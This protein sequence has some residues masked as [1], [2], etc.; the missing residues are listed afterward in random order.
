MTRFAKLTLLLIVAGAFALAGCG[1]DDNGLSAEDQARIAAAEQAAAMAASEAEQAKMDAAAADAEAEQAKQD[2]ADAKAEAEQATMA[3]ESEPQLD[4]IWEA[5]AGPA[6]AAD[7]LAGIAGTGPVYVSQLRDAILATATKYSLDATSAIAFLNE[8][9]PISA[10]LQRN[11]ANA[12]LAALHAGGH[13]AATAESAAV[14]AQGNQGPAGPAADPEAVEAMVYEEIAGA[15]IAAYLQMQVDA[16]PRDAG[17]GV[18]ASGIRA[19]IDATAA[20]YGLGDAAATD[21]KDHLT[22]VYP[23][24]ILE[25]TAVVAFLMSLHETGLL[26]ATSQAAAEKLADDAAMLVA[27]TDMDTSDTSGDSMG[28]DDDD[29]DT[30][31][32]M[33]MVS[34]IDDII[35]MDGQDG[36]KLEEVTYNDAS[37]DATDYMSKYLG[38]TTKTK[39]DDN[40]YTFTARPMAAFG[41]VDPKMLSDLYGGWMEYNF[42]GSLS[43]TEFGKTAMADNMRAFSVGVESGP[44]MGRKNGSAHWNGVFVGHHHVDLLPSGAIFDD[45][46][47]GAV[48]ADDPAT[49]QA[50][51]VGD[52]VGGSV[53]LA[54]S[55]DEDGVGSKVAATFDIDKG[56]LTE[57]PADI[58]I[59]DITIQ[60]GGNFTKT[61]DAA[62]ATATATDP[63]V[64]GA[65]T[66]VDGQFYGPAADEVGGT[67]VLTS[68]V[69][70]NDLKISGAF[71]AAD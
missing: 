17:G 64:A 48:D 63:T 43:E 12:F 44:P 32:D 41:D 53:D 61:I 47:R 42:F 40:L 58:V 2:A 28:G 55:F 9:H 5:I 66:M 20:K 29:T 16:I 37:N 15:A 18:P 4:A 27:D 26:P 56:K 23:I 62:V 7:V 19:A 39:I 25:P 24:A 68:P 38:E 45:T 57:A 54:V 3:T 30:M 21:A 36:K 51:F 71:G 50:V 1:G 35:A 33:T 22:A 8:T 67:M 14:V 70:D 65:M 60:R 13:L 49:Q 52:Q 69:T 6:I 31:P 34:Y 46:A 10:V 59:G 11:A